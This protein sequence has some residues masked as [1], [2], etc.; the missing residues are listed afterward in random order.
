MARADKSARVT[1]AVKAIRKRDFSDYSKAIAYY[2][3]SPT[4]VSRRIH[5]KTYSRKKVDSF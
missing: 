5:S 2:N 1:A 4:I 3:Y